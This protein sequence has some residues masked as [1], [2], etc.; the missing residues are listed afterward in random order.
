[1]RSGTH[2]T[3]EGDRTA[4]G[5]RCTSPRPYDPETGL[6]YNLFR[7]Y[8]PET[9]RYASPDPLGLSPAPNPVAYVTNPH[10][11]CAPFGLSPYP[12]GDGPAIGEYNSKGEGQD[13]KRS[14]RVGDARSW[15]GEQPRRPSCT[16][17]RRRRLSG[18][19][20]SR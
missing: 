13:L 5:D 15:R 7:H 20:D 2:N 19:P 12:N 9:G 4:G 8:D 18:T 16:R 1:M 6:Y 3:P 14:A 17:T 11:V 10:T